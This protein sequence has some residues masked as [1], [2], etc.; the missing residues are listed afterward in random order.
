MFNG[1]YN[2]IYF[3]CQRHATGNTVHIRLIHAETSSPKGYKF[4]VGFEAHK[5]RIQHMP[6][7]LA[8]RLSPV[9]D[10]EMYVYLNS[11]TLTCI[12]G[13]TCLTFNKN[14][15]TRKREVLLISIL[16]Q[17]IKR[18]P[19]ND[20]QSCIRPGSPEISTRFDLKKKT[21]LKK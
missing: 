7:P 20:Q 10:Y 11:S 12:E 3:F 15:R 16:G 19:L 5:L 14:T 1:R 13:S 21:K 17:L 2:P 4:M 9:A 6:M 18:L 8:T